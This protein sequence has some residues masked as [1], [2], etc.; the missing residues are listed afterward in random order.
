MDILVV[1]PGTAVAAI[2]LAHPAKVGVLVR[3]GDQHALM[4]AEQQAPGCQG[5]LIQFRA[6]FSL[7]L[8]NRQAVVLVDGVDQAQGALVRVSHVLGG[9]VDQLGQRTG[10]YQFQRAVGL[11]GAFE[12]A[13]D[14]PAALGA[15][16]V[17]K[18]RALA[19]GLPRRRGC[20]RHL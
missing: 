9:V 3:P 12:N 17:V 2:F 5:I 1:V 10:S 8:G 11:Q 20:G 16:Q 19:L 7:K 18:C 13:Q 15:H 14:T 4:R 6:L